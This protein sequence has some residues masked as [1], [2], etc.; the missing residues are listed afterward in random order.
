MAAIASFVIRLVGYAVLLGVAARIADYYWLANALDQVPEAQ[1]WHDAGF[2]IL[3][4]APLV[5]A[6]VAPIIRRLTFG[7]AIALAAAAVTAPFAFAR[8]VP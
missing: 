2:T 5:L 3:A 6:L 1:R 4:I 7:I 8:L